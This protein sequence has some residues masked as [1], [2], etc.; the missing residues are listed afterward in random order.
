LETAERLGPV[1]DQLQRAGS[2]AGFESPAYI[3]PS[4]RTQRQRQVALPD[5]VVLQRNLSEAARGLPFRV[6]RF[7]P[8]LRDVESARR[9]SPPSRA[10][11]RRPDQ[12]QARLAVAQRRDGWQHTIAAWVNDARAVAAALTGCT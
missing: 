11:L 5:G 2:L 12:S 1:L 10:D 4:E 6:E 8:F 7:Q 3:L 9:A